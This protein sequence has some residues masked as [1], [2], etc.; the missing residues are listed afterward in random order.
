MINTSK[1]ISMIEIKQIT[2]EDSFYQKERELRNAVL[3]R[4]IGL[5]DG[6]WEMNDNKSWHFV[7]VENSDVISCVL[8]KP[9]NENPGTAQLLQMA[10]AASAQGKGIGK[11]LIKA[12]LD[13][14]SQNNITEVTCHARESAANFYKSIGFEIYGSP[15][16][17]VGMTHYH[18]KFRLAE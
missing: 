14:C 16:Q 9:V 7:A 17:E 1:D 4:P 6:A 5:P 10:V 18:M 8:L 12:L 13:F 3:L 2:T 11:M 15:F